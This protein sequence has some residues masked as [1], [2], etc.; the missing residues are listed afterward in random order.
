VTVERLDLLMGGAFVR[1]CERLEIILRVEFFSI[2]IDC[3]Q[4]REDIVSVL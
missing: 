3:V 4:A 1:D 2:Y